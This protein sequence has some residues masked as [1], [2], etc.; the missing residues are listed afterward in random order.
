MQN[1]QFFHHFT[2]KPKKLLEERIRVEKQFEDID[3]DIALH[4]S[5]TQL[6]KLLEKIRNTAFD[7]I[8]DLAQS[9]TKVDIRL[10]VYEYPYPDEESKT[11]RKINKI[12]TTRYTG[13]VGKTAWDLFQQ[14]ISDPFLQELIRDSY[15]KEPQTFLGI[16]EEML[17]PFRKAMENKLS[18]IEGLI[19]HMLKSNIKT[20]QILKEWKVK[21]DSVLEG[22]L[23]KGM[24]QR[25][26][27]KDFIISR[28]GETYIAKCLETFSMGEYK[29][30]LKIYIEARSY[31]EFHPTIMHD[32]TKYRIGDPREKQELWNF[33]SYDAFQQV[34]KWA[35]QK[36][37]IKIFE[38][39][40]DNKRLMY[41]KTFIRYMDDVHLINEPKVA[42]IYFREFVVVE[43]GNI[44]AAYF[45]HRKGF[46]T[47]IL[48]TVKSSNFKYKGTQ[49]RERML[50]NR[51]YEQHG[52]RLFI[53]KLD[54]R[55][56]W[57]TKFNDQM[58]KYLDGI[59]E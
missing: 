48:P 9:L 39:D 34:K 17:A 7:K 3:K 58:S 2:F 14:D 47:F 26:L 20:E 42:F 18:I 11:R 6:P 46:E 15:F 12:L 57:Q 23:L 19:P 55:G 10:L 13:V 54:H 51:N 1:S 56:Y 52:I 31:E 28:D 22:A 44:G 21:S 53:N 8:A 59:N 27:H 16:K 50:K 25:G 43:F 33:L 35:I 40:P 37:L 41:W 45:Y 38:S 5:H 49:S 32:A 4:R 30:L 29:M 24:F 36:N